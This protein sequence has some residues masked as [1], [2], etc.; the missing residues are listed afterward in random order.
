MKLFSAVL[1]LSGHE[2]TGLTDGNGLVPR[3]RAWKPDLVLMDIQLPDIDGME[4]LG[5]LRADARTASMPVLAVTALAMDGDRERF[6]DAGFDD[7]VPKPVD[8]AALVA[9]VAEHC[10]ANR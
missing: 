2:V 9:T 4:A 6:L 10:G 5:R 1:G 3:M 7:Y 8:I